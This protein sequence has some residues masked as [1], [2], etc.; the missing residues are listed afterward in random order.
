MPPRQLLLYT[1]GIKKQKRG[2]H[3]SQYS[4][5]EIHRS[6]QLFHTLTYTVMTELPQEKKSKITAPPLEIQSLSVSLSL[7]LHHLLDLHAEELQQSREDAHV[8][9]EEDIVSGPVEDISF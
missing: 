1:A 8:I 3:S 9:E 7:P 6:T 4:T 5:Q 2:S